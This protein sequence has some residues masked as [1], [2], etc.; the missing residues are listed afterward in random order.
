M[1]NAMRSR[2]EL[3]LFHSVGAG[4]CEL[5]V[6]SLIG[7]IE[8]LIVIVFGLVQRNG[9]WLDFLDVGFSAGFHC[10]QQVFIEVALPLHGG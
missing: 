7:L 5:N 4:E 9:S 1:I 8:R 10:F 3:I 6:R 2:R